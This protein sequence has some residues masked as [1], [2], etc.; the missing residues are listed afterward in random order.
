MACCSRVHCRAD[1]VLRRLLTPSRQPSDRRQADNRMLSC[2][3]SVGD[4]NCF[5]VLS[6][7]PASAARQQLRPR[8]PHQRLFDRMLSVVSDPRV[9]EAACN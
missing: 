9:W 2:S 3:H 5:A 6:Y 8:F 4:L 7:W 1:A